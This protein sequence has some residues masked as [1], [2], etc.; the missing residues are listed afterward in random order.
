M[1]GT[2]KDVQLKQE[3]DT[4]VRS[5]APAILHFWASWCE[6]S[7]HMDQVLSHLSTDFPH[8]HFFRVE[9][10]EQSE[11]Y[12]AYSV[13]AVPFFAFSK[14]R[15][16]YFVRMVK[17]ADKIVNHGK[18]AAPASL[19]LAARPTVLETRKSL[20]LQQLINL[21]PVM[22]FMK[23]S[24]DEPRCGFSRKGVDILKKEKIKFGSFDI[25]LDNEVREG[26]KKYS[27]WPTFLSSIVKVSFL[28]GVTLCGFGS[29]VVNALKEENVSFG[30]F[31]IST[32]E[33]VRQGLKVLDIYVCKNYSF[34]K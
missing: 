29:K 26:L 33:E 31:D 20:R 1:G 16:Y 12:E 3:L 23:R 28:V 9:A 5:G 15:I 22:L 10:E 8:T 13:S 30:S 2:V 32:D 18:P 19:G 25:L 24:P 34:L 21:H 14:I 11:I 6:A 4:L 27:N 17:P 7:K